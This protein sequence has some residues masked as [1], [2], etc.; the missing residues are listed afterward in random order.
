VSSASLFFFARFKPNFGY[1]D[2]FYN[3]KFHGN[4]FIKLRALTCA[5]TD[6][7]TWRSYKPFSRLRSRQKATPCV[8]TTLV[9]L[10]ICPLAPKWFIKSSLQNVVE[11]RDTDGGQSHILLRGVSGFTCFWQMC[12]NFGTEIFTWCRSAI[13]RFAKNGNESHTLLRGVNT[14]RVQKKT[15]LLL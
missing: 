10:P 9:C 15:E 4:P 3:T 11:V 8:E 7:Q 5:K 13:T 14:R 2:R 6:R 12:M 1:P